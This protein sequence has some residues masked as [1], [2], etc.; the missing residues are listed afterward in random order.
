M[1]IYLGCDNNRV[2]IYLRTVASSNMQYSS[3]P[4]QD[5]NSYALYTLFYETASEASD[6][7]RSDQ[8]THL[9]THKW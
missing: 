9:R 1:L 2:Q 4:E 3:A 5:C 8:V 7:P 6:C